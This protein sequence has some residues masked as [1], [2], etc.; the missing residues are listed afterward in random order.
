MNQSIQKTD[1]TTGKIN[2]DST[3]AVELEDTWEKSNGLN[4]NKYQLYAFNNIKNTDTTLLP[5]YFSAINI[6]FIQDNV[7]KYIQE[8][9]NIKIK[10]N[11]DINNLLNN[12]VINYSNMKCPQNK[13]KDNLNFI[14]GN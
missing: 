12:M 13:N 4:Y 9:Q 6:K 11:Q 14:L 2:I 8:N 10:T 3:N 7:I 1:L 5:L